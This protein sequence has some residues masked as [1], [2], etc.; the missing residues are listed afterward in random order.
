MKKWGSIKHNT[1]IAE[2]LEKLAELD[3]IDKKTKDKL[4]TILILGMMTEDG[5]F[6]F[7]KVVR[8]LEGVKE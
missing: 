7:D 8:A 6:V 4:T 1:M 5:E 3:N 2:L